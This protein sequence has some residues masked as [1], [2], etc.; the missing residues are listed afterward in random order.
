MAI[1]LDAKL[2]TL[3]PLPRFFSIPKRHVGNPALYDQSYTGILE[4]WKGF[5]Q[6]VKD[7]FDS[8]PWEKYPSILH[9][10][11]SNPTANDI[12]FEHYVC[13]EE[14]STSGRYVQNALHVMTA[15]GKE[16]NFKT[17]F[18]D[19]KATKNKNMVFEFGPDGLKVK[20]MTLEMKMNGDTPQ[21]EADINSS[22]IFVPDY[23]LMD[24]NGVARAV[25]EAKNPWNH[26]FFIWW[27]GFLRDDDYELRR[28][29]GKTYRFF[30]NAVSK[31]IGPKVKCSGIC[32]FSA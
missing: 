4:E 8:R 1:P 13:G 20:P 18:G 22:H 16:M 26:P 23:A 10:K 31:L 30:N 32:I 24:G 14:T 17:L 2:L 12:N 11:S 6:E 5:E 19:W 25:G 7:F 15:V 28:L 27:F 3:E 9:Y 21:K 29:L